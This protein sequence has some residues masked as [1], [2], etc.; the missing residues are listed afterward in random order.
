MGVGI[1]TFPAPPTTSVKA[2]VTAAVGLF[3]VSVPASELIRDWAVIVTVP[4]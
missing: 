1:V 2:P 4:P 3:K